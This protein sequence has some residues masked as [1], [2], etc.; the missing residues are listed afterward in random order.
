MRSELV[1]LSEPILGFPPGGATPGGSPIVIGFE[2]KYFNSSLAATGAVELQGG[3]LEVVVNLANPLIGERTMTVLTADGGVTGTFGS[4]LAPE[5]YVISDIDYQA[6]AV[7]IVLRSEIGARL[8]LSAQAGALANYLNTTSMA[9]PSGNGAALSA[10][11]ISAAAT[12][13]TEN[14]LSALSPEIYASANVLNVETGLAVARS[15]HTGGVIST[16]K[17]GEGRA[18]ASSVFAHASQDGSSD[19]N[20]LAADI[21]G[22][23][24]G[25]GYGLSDQ[26]SVGAFF[27][28]SD[29][30]QTYTD[31]G[32]EAD[33]NAFHVGGYMNFNRER[34]RAQAFVAHSSGDV[35]TMKSIAA[36]NRTANG[37]ADFDALIVSGGVQADLFQA[38][39]VAII[40]NA[41]LT[42]VSTSRGELFEVGAGTAN[43]VVADDDTDFLFGETGLTIQ[44]AAPLGG[45]YTPYFSGGYQYELL[46]HGNSATARLPGET[47]TF[48]VDGLSVDRGRAIVAAGV[49]AALAPGVSIAAGYDAAFG[50]D[51]TRHRGVIN[52]SVGF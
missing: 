26:L 48:T 9:N 21:K 4:L 43:F 6:N 46:G 37:E 36:L 30:E 1:F 20:G 51:L 27:G 52:V 17:K 2:N 10:D 7:D 33:V 24:I 25:V 13:G 14:V 40:P 47:S 49:R 41:A 28:A 50:S 29:A 34:L 3:A 22:G 5:N 31:I 12:G 18:W 19:A 32:A 11:V 38:G 39:N 16:P 42:F 15:L 35:E 45:V 8:S 23:V 44:P